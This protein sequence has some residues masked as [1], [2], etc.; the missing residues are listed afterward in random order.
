MVWSLGSA[1]PVEKELI[2]A[3]DDRP[4]VKVTF[5]AQPSP[6]SLRA[7]RRAI[8][9]QMLIGGQDAEERAADAFT[10]EVIR[11]NII[12]WSGIGGEDGEPVQ[13]TMDRDTLDLDGK[14]VDVEMGTIS[15]FLTEPRLVEAADR[16]YVMPWA[17]ADA[18]KNGLSLS[19][20]GTSARA[21]QEPDTA[22]RSARRAAKAGA[23]TKTAGRRAPT[24]STKPRA[25]KAKLSGS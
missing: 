11:H 13:P 10:R 17:L 7:A 19:L 12:S 2:P 5:N 8:R 25:T 23:R 24:K 9:I 20:A 14:V 6:L 3:I 15:A 4:P 16:E 22:N 21:T 1:K 18:E